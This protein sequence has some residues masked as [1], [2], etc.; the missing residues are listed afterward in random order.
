LGTFREKGE[1]AQTA[2][3]KV[4]EALIPALAQHIKETQNR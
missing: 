2:V 4:V 3:K 1:V